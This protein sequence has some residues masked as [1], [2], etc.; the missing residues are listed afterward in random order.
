MASVA[1][2]SSRSRA[3]ERVGRLRRD[4]DRHSGYTLSNLVK[5]QILWFFL[6]CRKIWL[7]N[8]H[9][10]SNYC[11]KFVQLIDDDIQKAPTSPK[12][13]KHH[14]KLSSYITSTPGLKRKIIFLGILTWKI[15]GNFGGKRHK[16]WLR[17]TTYF[18]WNMSCPTC[19]FHDR[20]NIISACA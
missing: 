16:M 20:Q 17:S 1:V 19:P 14:W 10:N 4:M 9:F 5:K 8:W 12:I 11:Y 6:F 15:N 7:N 18:V 13:G 3:N 2:Y